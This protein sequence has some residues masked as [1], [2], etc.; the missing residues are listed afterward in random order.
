MESGRLDRTVLE[1]AGIRLLSKD[2]NM[3][4]MRGGSGVMEDLVELDAYYHESES[5][6]LELEQELEHGREREGSHPS[7]SLL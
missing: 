3:A 1:S 7:A 4:Q 6:Q 2:D 5:E